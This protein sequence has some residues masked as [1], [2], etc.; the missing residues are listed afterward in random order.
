MKPT[1]HAY[2]RPGIFTGFEGNDERTES[3]RNFYDA[4][5]AVLGPIEDAHIMR[6]DAGL[7]SQTNYSDERL[8]ARTVVEKRIE[9]DPGIK[10]Q[11]H[12]GTR[13]EG[14][15]GRALLEYMETRLTELLED[16]E[17]GLQVPYV[18]KVGS[19]YFVRLDVISR[20]NE[21]WGKRKQKRRLHR[22][23]KIEP[24]TTLYPQKKGEYKHIVLPDEITTREANALKLTFWDEVSYG[25]AM[26]S[27]ESDDL[28]GIAKEWL[29]AKEFHGDV[30]ANTVVPFIAALREE[31]ER[32]GD[33]WVETGELYFYLPRVPTANVNYGKALSMLF[34]D[35]EESPGDMVFM[36]NAED[37]DTA[38][39]RGYPVFMAEDH[40]Y[41]SIDA[42]LE[43][44]EELSTHPDVK[45]D[46]H[47]WDPMSIIPLNED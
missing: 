25:K 4:K 1:V 28:R 20:I 35:N 47:R 13:V 24:H 31:V 36:L 18:R 41:V 11:L 42:V 15:G 12:T 21:R 16:K 37:I 14:R 8:P 10:I 19:D 39:S 26:R 3:A 2:R 30:T 33:P 27:D 5:T 7:K 6:F 46:G 22:E 9:V 23:I 17:D 40:L 29:R 43:R 34:S 32:T 44:L 45:K 38:Q